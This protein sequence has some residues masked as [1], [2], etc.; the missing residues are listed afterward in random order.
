MAFY[1]EFLPLAYPGS[2]NLEDPESY[3]AKLTP[4]GSINL[5][6]S[7]ELSLFVKLALKGGIKRLL[8]NMEHLTYIDSSGIG[9]II[10]I[11]KLFKAAGGG[12]ALLNVPPKINEAFDL[13]NLREYVPIY[14]SEEKA[15][16]HFRNQVR[17]GGKP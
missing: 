7:S 6:N 9:L 1:V 14:Y 10:Q 3:A 17:G 4:R 12:F 2:F 13:V 11:R 5:D 15:L 16:D 8:I